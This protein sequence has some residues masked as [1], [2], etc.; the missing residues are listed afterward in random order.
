[1][2]FDG[3]KPRRSEEDVSRHTEHCEDKT[4]F[5]EPNTKAE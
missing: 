3:R 2:A 5:E 4:P 1:M